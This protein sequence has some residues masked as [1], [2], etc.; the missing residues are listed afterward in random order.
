MLSKIVRGGVIIKKWE[1]LGTMSQI[2]GGGIKTNKQ[3]CL[4]FKFG[5][6]NPHLGGGPQFSK[7]SEL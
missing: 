1:N 6:L 2:G 5:H 3:K 7:M 4:K